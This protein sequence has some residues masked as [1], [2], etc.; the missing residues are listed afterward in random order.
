MRF[1]FFDKILALESS[2]RVLAL[3][4]VSFD[5]AYFENHFDGLPVMPG[6]LIV[7]AIAQAAG[8][9]NF[10]THDESVRMV[11]GLIENVQ[12]GR[13]VGPGETLTLEA[14]ILF[15]HPE[16]V[17]MEGSARVGDEVVASVERLVFANEQVSR[18]EFSDAERAHF[19]YI[20]RGACVPSA[21]SS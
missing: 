15:V 10:I 9:L 4:H 8:W 7:E 18:G 21:Q 2:K 13:S 14:T 1:L 6:T 5:A 3:K 16:G 12:L 19:E 20:K 11:V 17:T